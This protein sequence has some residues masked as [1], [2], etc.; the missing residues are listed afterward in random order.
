MWPFLEKPRHHHQQPWRSLRQ[1][2][3]E[4]RLSAPSFAID[5]VLCLAACSQLPHTA[6]A[7]TMGKTPLFC[8][9]YF[10]FLPGGVPD[11]LT[12]HTASS[13]QTTLLVSH[14]T[15]TSLT[16]TTAHIQ[17]STLTMTTW[18]LLATHTQHTLATHQDQECSPTKAATDPLMAEL[19]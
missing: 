17:P 8:G 2:S 1:N 5:L 13:K 11:T 16:S 18:S 9:R 10:P 7:R 6:T 15:T 19:R 4:H 3:G 12:V 14:T